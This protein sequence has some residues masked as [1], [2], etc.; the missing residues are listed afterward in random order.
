M[1]PEY[2]YT[3]EY[4]EEISYHN[5]A[6]S[7]MVQAVEKWGIKSQERLLLEEMAELVVALMH[8][9]RGR[10]GKEAVLEELADVRM[11]ADQISLFFGQDDVRSW[12]K[13]KTD[14]LEAILESDN[15]TTET[16]PHKPITV[17]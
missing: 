4:G 5:R 10:V 14:R 13:I 11:M 8:F 16:Q 9:S 12:M 17:S 3:N 7:L 1:I 6:E 2:T 15:G